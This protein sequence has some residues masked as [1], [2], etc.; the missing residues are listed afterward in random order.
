M[1]I[2]REQKKLGELQAELKELEESLR[3]DLESK[4]SKFITNFVFEAQTLNKKIKYIG[5]KS[6]IQKEKDAKEIQKTFLKK[7]V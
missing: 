1:I 2:N 5:I 6:D 7:L 4:L 3:H